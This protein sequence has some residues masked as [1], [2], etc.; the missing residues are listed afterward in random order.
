VSEDRPVDDLPSA[1]ATLRAEFDDFKT[2]T[3]ARLLRCPTGTIEMSFLGVKEGTLLL[4]GATLNRADFPQLWQWIT[5][6][7]LSPSVF[8][9]G[10]GTTTFVLPDFRGRYARGANATDLVGE[11]VGTDT[12]ALITAN[13]PQHN[14]SI[15]GEGDHIHPRNG[16]NFF[17]SEN[18]GHG[19][20]NRSGKVQG[21]SSGPEWPYGTDFEPAHNHTVDPGSPDGGHSHGGATGNTG[22]ATPTAIDKKPASLGVNFLVWT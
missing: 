13:L 6:R 21:W 22:S 20:H 11:V 16:G 8:G 1:I 10:N 5:D 3:A 15:P 19:G 14:H 17:T 18:G 4:N 12:V 2:T 9:A 7:S